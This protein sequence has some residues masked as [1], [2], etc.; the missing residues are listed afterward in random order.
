MK[1]KPNKLLPVYEIQLNVV[2]HSLEFKYKSKTR[3]LKE[4]CIYNNNPIHKQFWFLF[5]CCLFIESS[6]LLRVKIYNTGLYT[7]ILYTKGCVNRKEYKG[8]SHGFILPSH[9][10]S[11]A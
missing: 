8:N 10:K 4:I 7:E 2:Y 6:V 1:L 11:W 9:I 3:N 5:L